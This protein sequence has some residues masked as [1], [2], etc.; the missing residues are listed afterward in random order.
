MEDTKER[1]LRGIVGIY[2][3][4]RKLDKIAG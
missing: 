2:S 4:N 1:V 3:S